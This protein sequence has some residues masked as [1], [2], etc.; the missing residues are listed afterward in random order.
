VLTTA[1]TPDRRLPIAARTA[2][3]DIALGVVLLLVAIASLALGK[4]KLVSNIV[5]TDVL[6][7]GVIGTWMI[8]AGRGDSR[9]EYEASRLVLPLSLVFGGSLIASTHVGTRSFV[10]EDLV[11]DAGAFAVFLGALDL[12]RRNGV[13]VMR[14]ALAA[15]FVAVTMLSLTMLGD[16]TLRGSATFPNP[17]IPAHLLACA[18]LLFVLAPVPNRLRIAAV[19]AI[20]FGMFRAGSFGAALQAAIGFSYIVVSRTMA[21]TH[22]R[23]RARVALL[24]LLGAAAAIVVILMRDYMASAPEKVDAGLSAARLDRSLAGRLEVWNE[25]LHNFFAHPFGTGPGSSRAL[26]LL[27]GATEPHSEPLAYL[28]ERGVLAF[29]GLVLLWTVLWRFMRPGGIARAM[30]CGYLVNS[31]FRETLH[32]R[33]WWLLLP[34]A[35]VIDERGLVGPVGRGAAGSIAVGG[36]P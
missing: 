9:S 36:S 16:Q 8:H 26:H 25:T 22:Q 2:V 34:L 6:L 11:R 13:E 5:V 28:A 32:Y 30:F 35:M 21:R 17:N 14:W 4:P 23:E 1:A 15:L 33:H 27:Q 10:V 19:I 31:L 20:A 7:A 12:F 3:A 18:L 29:V 24:A